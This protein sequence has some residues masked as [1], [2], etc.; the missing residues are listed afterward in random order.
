MSIPHNGYVFVGDGR[1][2]LVLRNDGDGQML[3]LKTER[4]FT[5]VN[6]STHEQG[7]ERPGR[8]HSSVGPG[9]SSV[10][11]TDWHDLEEHKFAHQVA[12]MLEKVVHERGVKHLTIVAPP[13]TL[14]ELRKTFHPDVKKIIATEIDKDLTRHPLGDIEKHLAG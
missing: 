5:D 9:R 13:R 6:P 14:A 8:A 4:V 10:T 2:A 12:A 7:A 1:K 3:N 11:Q